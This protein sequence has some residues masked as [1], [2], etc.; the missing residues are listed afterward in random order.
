MVVKHDRDV[1]Y[2]F[3][4]VEF[5]SLKA[6]VTVRYADGLEI[7]GFKIIEPAEG[8]PWVGMP[9]REVIRD[10][11]KEYFD[12]VRFRSAEVRKEFC[13]KILKAWRK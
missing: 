12:I 7:R 9:S 5:G 4:N 13:D 1:E 6:L 10:G 8:E 3:K 11:K 2:E